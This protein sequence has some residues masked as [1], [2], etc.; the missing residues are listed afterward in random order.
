MNVLSW[1]LVAH[2]FYARKPKSSVK[3]CIINLSGQNLG[4]HQQRPNLIF[5]FRYSLG[6]LPP[7]L[8]FLQTVCDDKSSPMSST[9]LSSS[10]L[11][12]LIFQKQ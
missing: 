3:Q 2:I 8:L 10:V 4:F 1:Y 5:L 9:P 12:N 11:P 6:I 7:C